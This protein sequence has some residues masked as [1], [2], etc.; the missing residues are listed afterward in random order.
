MPDPNP[1][2]KFYPGDWLADSNVQAMTAEARGAYIQL[3][4]L[5]WRDGSLPLNPRVLARMAGLSFPIFERR[6]WPQLS[7]CFTWSEDGYT[8]KRL[9]RERAQLLAFRA[10]RSE[11][12]KRGAAGRWQSDGSAIPQPKAQPKAQPMA[13]DARSDLR[14]QN[15]RSEHT[16]DRVQRARAREDHDPE[17]DGRGQALW[18]R[19]RTLMRDTR[20]L[21][22]PL[23]PKAHDLPKLLDAVTLI[24]DDA[25]LHARLARFMALTPEQA[26]AL[27]VKAVT[28]GYFVMALPQ[29]TDQPDEN[30][31]AIAAWLETHKH[32]TH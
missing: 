13:N 14:D 15:K 5:C 4:C 17:V 16:E 25:D 19:W 20:K 9:E 11:A 6:V 29:L 24:A 22:L 30:D 8:Q 27:N 21:T 18:D 23:Q 7:P 2:F 32:D 12:G 31:R 28:L 1:W 10:E 3:L 26:A